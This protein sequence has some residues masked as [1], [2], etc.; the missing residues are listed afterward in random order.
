MNKK[1]YGKKWEI[2]NKAYVQELHFKLF[3]M[4]GI[5]KTNLIIFKGV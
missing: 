3:T 2:I 4:N 1:G 5:I